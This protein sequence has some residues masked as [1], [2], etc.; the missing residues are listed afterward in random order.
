MGPGP[1]VCNQEACRKLV[2]KAVWLPNGG[3]I[4]WVE[5]PFG[6]TKWRAMYDDPR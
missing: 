5:I 2:L 6:R 1:L 4:S 3:K